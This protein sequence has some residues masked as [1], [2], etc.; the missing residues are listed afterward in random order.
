[1]TRAYVLAFVLFKSLPDT[2]SYRTG[3][4]IHIYGLIFF[5]KRCAVKDEGCY[6]FVRQKM[7]LCLHGVDFVKSDTFLALFVQLWRVSFIGQHCSSQV[8]D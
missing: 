4:Y 1:M 3:I 6:M 7:G 2:E 5:K 8:S